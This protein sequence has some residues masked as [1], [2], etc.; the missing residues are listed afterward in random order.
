MELYIIT[1]VS[2][3]VQLISLEIDYQV[4]DLEYLRPHTEDLPIMKNKTDY[5]YGPFSD[6]SLIFS[7]DLII[8]LSKV[9]MNA[10][11]KLR[12]KMRQTETLNML[13]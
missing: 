5:I 8:I 12:Q 7:I 10:Q 2:L 13:K 1:K 4:T 11:M 9:T 6:S 3:E